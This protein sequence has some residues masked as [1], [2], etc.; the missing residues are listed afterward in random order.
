MNKTAI[1]I[2]LIITLGAVAI[3][4]ML[5]FG[6]KIPEGYFALPSIFKN[7][8]ETLNQTDTQKTDEV[9]KISDTKKTETKTPAEPF[10]TDISGAL[11]FKSGSYVLTS[12]DQ[13][14]LVRNSGNAKLAAILELYIGRETGL[15]GIIDPRISQEITVLSVNGKEILTE[16]TA[17]DTAPLEAE[18]P[19]ES[20][21]DF[22]SKLTAAQKS[23]ISRALG[24]SRTQELIKNPALKPATKELD[25]IA[26]C[27]TT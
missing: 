24:S 13:K 20:F 5:T 3:V 17:L 1:T 15:G 21:A 9:P 26:A 7:D 22:Y 4:A 14:F 8:T 27:T 16:Q 23:C 11:S 2:T 10:R 12:S 19:G 6:G 18:I 25:K